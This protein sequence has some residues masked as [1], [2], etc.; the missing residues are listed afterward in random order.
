MVSNS[1]NKQ[2]CNQLTKC[3]IN[4]HLNHKTGIE[5]KKLNMKG[6]WTNLLIV[7]GIVNGVA[8]RWNKIWFR[9]KRHT[10]LDQ[11]LCLKQIRDG[12]QH[13]KQILKLISFYFWW[14]VSIFKAEATFITWWKSL[15]LLLPSPLKSTW[16]K[17]QRNK[18]R[19]ASG[20]WRFTIW[21]KAHQI[22]QY[23]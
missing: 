21:E 20:P 7:Q 11:K 17:R 9:N 13:I 4:K 19:S 3:T 2:T 15:P 14:T 1:T 22:C 18:C 5:Y 6:R 10:L 16:E 12:K 23:L 8:K